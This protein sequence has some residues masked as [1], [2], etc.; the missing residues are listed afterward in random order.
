MK[1][2]QLRY[3]VAVADSDL[4]VTAASNN[5]GTSQP[6]VSKQLRLLELELGFS[7]FNRRGRA[8][9]R[10]TPAGDQVVR[11]AQRVLHEIESIRRLSDDLL[12]PTRG[13]LSVGA[14]HTQARHVLPQIITRFRQRYPDVKLKL[15]QGTLGQIAGMIRADQ[16]DFA[17]GTGAEELFPEMT[18]LPGFQ[19]S[20]VAVVPAAHPLAKAGRMSLHALAEHPLIGDPFTLSGPSVLRKSF[21]EAGLEPNVVLEARDSDLI[22]AYVRLGLGVGILARMAV[23]PAADPDLVAIESPDLFP[24]HTAW[25]GFRSG[26]LLRQFM[27]E[28][29]QLFAPHLDRR[30][31][32]LANASSDRTAMT[33]LFSDV[34]LPIR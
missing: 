4:N 21:A 32:D 22:K 9:T 30:R 27:Y 19:W 11:R 26:L 13:T 15:H 20:R 5:L 6:G 23:N 31:V 1:I 12:S 16:I 8:L 18:V 34:A 14:T 7:I 17:I 33:A 28:F 3:L 29:L 10:M 2:H 25:I 24:N